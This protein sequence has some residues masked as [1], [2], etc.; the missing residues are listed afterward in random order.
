M[1]AS[2]LSS[3]VALD[4]DR[5]ALAVFLARRDV[6]RLC[7]PLHTA[8]G[9]STVPMPSRPTTS[10]SEHAAIRALPHSS[11]PRS[12]PPISRG[13]GRVTARKEACL[14][15]ISK[16]GSHTRSHLSE[17]R[18]SE[19]GL[20]ARGDSP[21][22]RD[23]DSNPSLQRSHP[24]HA[25][26]AKQL[27]SA[28]D[29]HLRQLQAKIARYTS[30]I[31]ELRIQSCDK[32]SSNPLTSV[33]LPAKRSTHDHIPLKKHQQ[34]PT[35][36][37]ASSFL[38]R[39]MVP[40]RVKSARPRRS[41]ASAHP[42]TVQ[43]IF[44][45][46]TSPAVTLAR[47]LV[48]QERIRKNVNALWLQAVRALRSQD[49]NV[50]LLEPELNSDSPSAPLFKSYVHTD[51]GYRESETDHPVT[52]NPLP[53]RLPTNL[54]R[55][56]LAGA[57]RRRDHLEA[58][59]KQL[60][61]LNTEECKD[62]RIV[63]VCA[64]FADELVDQLLD[65]IVIE[66]ERET[67]N[68]VDDIV[69]GELFTEASDSTLTV[70]KTPS[71]LDL[72]PADEPASQLDQLFSDTQANGF[73]PSPGSITL[74]QDAVSVLTS[75]CSNRNLHTPASSTNRVSSSTTDSTVYSSHFE[76]TAPNSTQLSPQVHDRSVNSVREQLSL[77]LISEQTSLLSSATLIA[78]LALQNS[79][80]ATD[81]A[82]SD[83]LIYN[84]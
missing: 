10:N 66:I 30:A 41:V 8:D 4:R 13:S 7:A 49:E 39:H 47:P 69:E 70:N 25:P 74:S 1:Y 34:Q 6:A 78:N 51:S 12:D 54:H 22:T 73:T 80:D 42:R 17:N 76:K 29:S 83:H 11:K 15:K 3:P 20:P 31:A 38:H 82:D 60:N 23:V 24:L 33:R 37:R 71:D 46:P 64:K 48:E 79:V 16:F 63:D 18:T 26:T 45:R 14:A 35:N 19:D 72:V 52:N 61:I 36:R 43:P 77:D 5:L 68:L 58:S 67:S 55:E 27:Q 21:P 81:D 53:L 57:L 40:L 9:L 32:T 50:I 84:Q 59:R 44:T 56:L 65:D 2:Q 28:K 75:N 62:L